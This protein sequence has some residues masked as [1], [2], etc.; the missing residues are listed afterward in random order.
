MLKG[1]DMPR[2]MKGAMAMI[3]HFMERYGTTLESAIIITAEFSGIAI[4]E[5]TSYHER[6][7][8]AGSCDG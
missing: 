5:L 6:E 2:D 7:E 1:S 4:N 8:K 3:K